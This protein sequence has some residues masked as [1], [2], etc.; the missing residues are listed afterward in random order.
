MNLLI[1]SA[2]VIDKK[3]EFHNQTLDIL[4]RG[5]IISDIDKNIKNSKNYKELKLNNLSI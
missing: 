3:S 2:T 4:I 1:R 5:G